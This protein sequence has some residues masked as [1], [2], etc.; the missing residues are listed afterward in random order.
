MNQHLSCPLIMD[1]LNEGPVVMGPLIMGPVIMGLVN[2]DPVIMGPVNMGPVILGPVSDHGFGDH[3]SDFA[4]R[5]VYNRQITRT[6]GIYTLPHLLWVT[7]QLWVCQECQ[8][9]SS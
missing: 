2:G 9:V 6:T 4:S 1:L 5:R 7:E 3:G 8:D